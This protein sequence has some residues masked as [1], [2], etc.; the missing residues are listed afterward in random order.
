[1]IRTA[2]LWV[3]PAYLF[4][5][6]ILGGSVQA[7]WG[8]AVLQLA[9]IAIIAWGALERPGTAMSR[10]AR[11]LA[12]I[13]ALAIFWVLVQLIPLPAAWWTELGPRA[14]FA[15][16]YARLGLPLPALPLSVAPYAT[17][18]TLLTLIPPIALYVAVERLHAYRTAFLVAALAAGTL[19]GILLGLLQVNSAGSVQS[20]YYLY[21]DV[22]VGAATGFFA[23]ANHM[24]SLL[25]ATLP[26]LAALAAGARLSQRRQS[27]AVITGAAALALVV[28]VGIVLNGS[29]AAFALLPAVLV[30]SALIVFPV[31]S[32]LRR[33]AVVGAAIL[34]AGGVA[35][36][37]LTAIGGGNVGAAPVE[38]VSSRP[39]IF[40][41]TANAARAYFPFGS[42]LG[43]YRNVYDRFEDPDR[44]SRTRSSHAHNDYAELALELGLPG[45]LLILLFAFWWARAA[46][47]TWRSPEP[48]VY[49][50]AAAVASAAILA[51]SLVDYPLRTAAMAAVF[52]MSLAFLAGRVRAAPGEPNALRPTRHLSLD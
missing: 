42:G 38:A 16:V 32:R 15:E 20:P 25:L 8:N 51:H 3:A 21:P 2:R 7:I 37:N 12:L 48:E 31:T 18:S 29:L 49:A 13:A 5:C 11:Q 17:L 6:L 36:L 52:A 4:A 46:M 43:T 40:A 27:G 34:L 41:N 26:F 35:A 1:V 45:I 24:A 33:G 28:V 23:N 39:A 19:G 44:V 9:G 47:Q 10:P 30:G 22:N 50:R 14:E